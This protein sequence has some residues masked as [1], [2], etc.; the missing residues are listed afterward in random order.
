MCDCD[1]QLFIDHS[2]KFHCELDGEGIEYAWLCSK[3]H[4]P[5]LTQAKRKGKNNFR[6][7]VEE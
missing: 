6:N 7:I 3:N 1:G 2:P 5:G 4:Y